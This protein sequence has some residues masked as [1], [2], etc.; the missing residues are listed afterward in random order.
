RR[1]LTARRERPRSRRAAEHHD[2]LAPFV[3]AMGFSPYPVKPAARILSFARSN[4]PVLG[5]LLNH[6][7]PGGG[8]GF[9]PI[10]SGSGAPPRWLPARVSVRPKLQR[11]LRRR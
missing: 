6:S 10:S 9:S 3:P 2:E 4:R 8:A 7:E 5:P 11:T 1:L